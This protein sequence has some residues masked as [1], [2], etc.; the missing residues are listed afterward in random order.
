MSVVDDATIKLGYDSH[1][2]LSAYDNLVYPVVSRRSRGLSLGIN[3]NPDKRCNFDCVYCQVERPQ[4]SAIIRPDIDQLESELRHWLGRLREGDYR[5]YLLKDIALAGDGE[6][7]SEKQLPQ[8]LEL[9][10][11]LKEEYQLPE[12]VKLILFTNGSGM[13]RKDLQ[14]IYPR[15]FEAAG[16]VWFKLDY[17][18]QQSLVEIN[19]TN[20]KFDSLIS[21]LQRFGN[22]YPVVLQSCFFQWKGQ[23]FAVELY[24]PYIELVKTLISEGLQIQKI[25]AYTLARKPAEMDAH[26]WPDADMDELAE[27]LRQQCALSVELFYEKGAE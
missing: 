8:V 10:L 18:D 16:E 21:K 2:R 11:T 12:S 7:T 14:A 1:D 17:W 6:P 27:Q 15:F 24:Q 23:R 20:L 22:K 5:G 25:Q 26:P 3:L 4:P 13:D 9:L 19:R